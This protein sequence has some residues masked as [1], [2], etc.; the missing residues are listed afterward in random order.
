VDLL[1]WDDI[2]GLADAAL[3]LAKNS[4]RNLAVGLVPGG[5]PAANFDKQRALDDIA[6]AVASGHLAVVSR[7]QVEL[8][9]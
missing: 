4:G 8:A 7:R 9:R 6:W 1:D 5:V 2:V 3:Y